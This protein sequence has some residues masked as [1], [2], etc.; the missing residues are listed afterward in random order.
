MMRVALERQR[1]ISLREEEEKRNIVFL[2]LF[3]PLS[4]SLSFSPTSFSVSLDKDEL[5]RFLPEDIMQVQY[6]C[7]TELTFIRYMYNVYGTQELAVYLY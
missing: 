7:K 5:L 4:L 3:Y 1:H 6:A 2:F